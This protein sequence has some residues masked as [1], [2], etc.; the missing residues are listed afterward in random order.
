MASLKHITLNVEQCHGWKLGELL[1]SGKAIISTPLSRHLPH[2]LEHAKR[3]RF[4]DGSF[5]EIKKAV[6]LLSENSNYRQQL[7]RNAH[8]YFIEYL[9]P[10]KCIVRMLDKLSV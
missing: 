6:K 2:P 10:E 5:E 7:E 4:V 3:L 1:A 9:A 8:D